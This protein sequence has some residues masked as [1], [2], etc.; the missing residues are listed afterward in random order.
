MPPPRVVVVGAVKASAV[1]VVATNT[2]ID[3]RE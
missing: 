2:M 1:A 3:A